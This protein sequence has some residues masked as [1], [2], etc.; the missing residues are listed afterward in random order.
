MLRTRKTGWIGFDLGATSV[1]A[2][3]AVRLAGEYF[4]RAAAV[5]PRPERWDAAMLTE[6]TPR[7]SVDE[8]R[9]AIS[10]GDRFSGAAASIVLPMP[11]CEVAQ[12][13]AAIAEKRGAAAL[14]RAIEAETHQTL[15]DHVVDWRPSPLK[16]DRLN[17]VTAPRRWSD[18]V[19]ADVAAAGR[20][21]RAIDALPWA[22]ARAVGM[23]HR[24]DPPTAAVAVDWGHSTATACLVHGGAP[25]L[26]RRLKDCGYQTIV[27]AAQSELRLDERDAEALLQKYGLSCPGASAQCAATMASVV[28][29]PLDR[30]HRELKRTLHYWHGQA[31]DA[32]PEVIYLFGG[33]ASLVGVAERMSEA[34][35][36]E[37]RIWNLPP[38]TSSEADHLPPA[39]L[40]GPALG[41]SALAWA[42]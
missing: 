16:P 1:K 33:G 24:V 26:V 39:H 12:V 2:A 32:V 41:L 5:I 34:L 29:E 13:D 22:L 7:T 4:I 10:V 25:A 19:S 27:A 28:A 36:I 42:M 21:C 9:A 14:L 38:E 30:F 20:H 18:Q 31:R 35:G 8:L 37:T 15:E 6:G 40:L 17:V 11:L 23:V 3:Q